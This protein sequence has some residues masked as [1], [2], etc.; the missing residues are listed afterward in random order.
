M[1]YKPCGEET[2]V[3]DELELNINILHSMFGAYKFKRNNG[4]SDC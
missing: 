2:L 1:L 3:T 4:E